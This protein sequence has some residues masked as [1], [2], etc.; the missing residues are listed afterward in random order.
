MITKQEALNYHSL[1]RPGK[2][3]VNATK[4]TITQRD[5]SLAYTPGVA[6]PCREIVKNPANARLYTARGNLVAVV[7]NG[8]AVLGLGNIGPLAGKPVMEGKGV[9]FKRF[10]D[11]DVFDIELN[12]TDID[13]FVRAVELMEPTFGGINLEDIKSP[14]CFE[15]ERRLI[16]AMD[17]PVFHDDQHGTAIISAAALLNAVEL[18]GKKLEEIKI[19]ISGAGASALSCARHY[20]NFGVRR[21]NII[22]CDSKGPI[23]EGRTEGMN[24]YKAEFAVATEAR[25]LAEAMR[26]ADVFLGL[27]VGG[28]VTGE[29]V[30]SMAEKPIVF[31]LANPDPEISYPE[32]KAARPDVI[33]ATGRSDYPN[34]VNNVLGFPFIFRGALDVHAKKINTEMKIAATKALAALAKEDVP[35]EVAK[36]YGAAHLTF[37]PEYII[38]KPF[39]P[40]VLTWE[41]SAVA[42]AAMDSGVAEHTI[43]IDKYKDELEARLGK[44][45]ELMRVIF[46]KAHSNPKRIV[47]PEGECEQ[48]IRAGRQIAMEGI[49]HPILLGNPERIKAEA[50]KLHVDLTGVE[51][52]DPAT[53]DKREAYIME[54]YR[55]RQ[56]KGVTRRR[57]RNLM[58]NPNYFGTMMIKN[59][60]ADG[61]VSGISQ[62]YADT[63]RPAL[64]V[65]PLRAGVKHVAGMYLLVFKNKIKVLAD[66]TVNIEPDSEVLAE[67]ALLA[68]DEAKRFGLKPRVALLSF[69]NFGSVKHPLSEKVK[70]AVEIIKRT[71]PQLEVD[72]ELHADVAVSSELLQEHF[73]FSTL[74]SE[75]NVLIF[76]D[77][78]S[79]NIAY[80]LLYKLSNATAI[81]PI[82]VGL[83]K[84]VNLLQ[85]A[86]S[87]VEDI[88]YMTAITVLDAQSLEKQLQ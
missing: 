75:A 69:S 4:P 1:D 66:V 38:P 50:E 81:G 41:A 86:A 31:A 51:L 17:I 53:S 49:A 43:E 48:V 85:F 16:E 7:T 40:R 47:L 46:H 64:Q 61:M 33:I 8:T 34:Q 22:M 68:A 23:Y 60:D 70:K 12:T 15:I 9:L 84:P 87:T 30:R 62:N 55:L 88:V 77:L 18:A 74:K 14:E 37:G 19:V 80:K 54:L 2:I 44:S 32:A 63:L 35:D 72:G 78:T 25:T 10:S 39:D 73:P 52:L 13:E 76:P 65:I 5:L 82:L 6:E 56:R 20:L 45:R 26:G 71:D 79:G 11:I 24:S 67:I 29:M 59:G 83:S 58:D 36:A 3:E 21:E 57:A 28:L 27:S 42:Q